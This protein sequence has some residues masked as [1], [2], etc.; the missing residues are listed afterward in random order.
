MVKGSL[1]GFEKIKEDANFVA[2]EIAAGEESEEG[3]Y[4][5]DSIEKVMEFD[6]EVVKHDGGTPVLVDGAGPHRAA[7]LAG[8]LLP[9]DDRARKK[10][11]RRSRPSWYFFLEFSALARRAR[12]NSGETAAAGK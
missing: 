11:E 2:G 4:F 3:M 7:G 10:T 8:H 12:I 6:K 1:G 5:V 9:G